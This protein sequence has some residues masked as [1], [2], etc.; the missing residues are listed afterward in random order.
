MTYQERAARLRRSSPRARFVVLLRPWIA[1]WSSSQL[2]EP[3]AVGA[4]RLDQCRN[5]LFVTAVGTRVQVSFV[6]R[7][8]LGASKRRQL[9]LRALHQERW[10]KADPS[11]VGYQLQ[12]HRRFV[13]LERNVR[14]NPS[15][16]SDARSSPDG[17]RKAITNRSFS[18]SRTETSPG[19]LLRSGPDLH[20]QGQVRGGCSW[21]CS[22]SRS[23]SR[24][25]RAM[26]RRNRR[27]SMP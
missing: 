2:H 13:C 7:Q 26:A 19:W 4:H 10:R 16:P 5:V 14:L 20:R 9:R 25:S 22:L 21:M 18:V 8:R 27:C 23:L 15:P 6:R 24:T 1:F 17:V 12:R 3:L 11:T